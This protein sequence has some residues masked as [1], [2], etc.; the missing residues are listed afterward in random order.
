M[1]YNY[2]GEPWMSDELFSDYHKDAYGFRP[3]GIIMDNWNM[4][5]PAEKQARWD[6]LGDMVANN[7]ELAKTKQDA[8]LNTLKAEIEKHIS[9]GAKDRS[10]ALR[11]MTQ[12]ERFYSGQCVEHWVWERGILFTPYGKELVQEL[13]KIVTYS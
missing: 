2:S 13:C 12:N 9:L 10:E 1:T 6:Q 5:P 11:I 8:D 7:A 4:M 3:R